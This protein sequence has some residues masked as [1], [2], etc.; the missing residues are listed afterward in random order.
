MIEKLCLK[1]RKNLTFPIMALQIPCGQ[2]DGHNGI[3]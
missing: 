3:P 1:Q 2:H